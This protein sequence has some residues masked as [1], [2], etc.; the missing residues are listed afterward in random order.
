MT[1][2]TEPVRDPRRAGQAYVDPLE[3]VWCAAAAKIGFRVQRSSEVYAH[4][5][6][7]GVIFVGTP[8]TLDPDDSVAQMVFH[9]LCHALV[10]AP[11]G[12][13]RP[14]WG[15]DN[16]TDRD[17]YRERAALRLQRILALRVGLAGLLAPTTDYRAFYDALGAFPLHG[18]ETETELARRGLDRSACA[19][20]APHLE[21]AL[22]VTRTIAGQAQ[23]Y[24]AGHVL[25]G[26]I[27]ALDPR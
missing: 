1:E 9:E 2:R 16:T 24:A 6:G 13:R 27:T 19:P 25:P 10:Q 3:L 18:P 20:F 23:T 17:A 8:E 12:L 11:D 4:F 21:E 14:D 22:R 7:R 5:D 26:A 15:L